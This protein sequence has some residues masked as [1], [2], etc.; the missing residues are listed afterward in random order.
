MR[1]VILF[2]NPVQHALSQYKPITKKT[3][4]PDQNGRAFNIFNWLAYAPTNSFST[5]YSAI[6]T[7]FNAAPFLI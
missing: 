1:T 3:K 2:I 5:I 6:W 7:A 4:K